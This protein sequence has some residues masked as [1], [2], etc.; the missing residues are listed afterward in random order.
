MEQEKDFFINEELKNRFLNQYFG[1]TKENYHH[2]L[3]KVSTLFEKRYKRDI[4]TSNSHDANDIIRMINNKTANS[5][6]AYRA[7]L[8]SYV[9]FC[10]GE[11]YEVPSTINWFKIIVKDDL[12]KMIRDSEIKTGIYVTREEIYALADNFKEEYYYFVPYILAF[13]SVRGKKWS[14]LFNLKKKDIDFDNNTITIRNIKDNSIIRVIDNI[15][16]RS[17]NII[18]KGLYIQSIYRDQKNEEVFD[19]SEYVIKGKKGVSI[20]YNTFYGKYSNYI[21]KVLGVKFTPLTAWKSGLYEKLIKRQ[22][23]K[24]SELTP[25]DYKDIMNN[26]GTQNYYINIKDDYETVRDDLFQ[27]YINQGLL[28]QG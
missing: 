15:D 1:T 23:E 10:I 18:N 8:S 4:Y 13:E 20:N 3:K 22:R 28:K 24:D 26:F 9:D 11:G 19:E 25:T 16:I 17:M 6:N 7:V 5:A 2:I 21:T 12:K 14:E 27:R